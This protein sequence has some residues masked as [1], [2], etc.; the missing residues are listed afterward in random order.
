MLSTQSVEEIVTKRFSCRSYERKPLETAHREDL[1]KYLGTLNKGPFGSEVR[2]DL[3]AASEGDAGALKGLGTYGF[4]R[5]P[6][7]FIIGAVKSGDRGL[8]DYGYLMEHAAL[9]VTSLGLGSC[10]LGGSFTR[11]SFSARINPRENE[12][13]PAVVS[14]GYIANKTSMVDSVIRWGAGSDH[15]KPWNELFFD[16]EYGVQ[17]TGEAAGPWAL[18]LEMVRRAPSA[19]NR[20]PWRVIKSGG[21]FHF[22]LERSKGYYERNKRLLNMA[23]MQRIDMGIAL[24]HFELAA[25]EMKMTGSWQVRG[26]AAPPVP[27]GVVY[28]ASWIE[29]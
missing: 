8:E 15:R 9:Y 4:I 10:W 18:P 29:E 7:G 12:T 17:F 25:R 26:D 28:T 16:N 27:D 1:I 19:S 6:A 2:F 3:A 5:D 23:D 22:Y 13:V 21:G 24:C 11:S 14:V 20:Q